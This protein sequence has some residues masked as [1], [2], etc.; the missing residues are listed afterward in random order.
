[1]KLVALF[2]VLL[3]SGIAQ[4]APTASAFTHKGMLY[5]TV[6]G[7]KCNSISGGL[8]VDGICRDDRMTQNY[9]EECSAEVQLMQTE[10][11]C[12]EDVEARVV[13]LDLQKENVAR[14]AK[15]LHLRYGGEVITVEVNR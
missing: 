12:G 6:L 11:Y 10:M 3:L 8:E 7:D 9:A 13:T 15:T 5:I 1:M 4:A 14:E 2:S